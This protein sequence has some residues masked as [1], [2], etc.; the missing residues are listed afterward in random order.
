M[1]KDGKEPFVAQIKF[2][3]RFADQPDKK[4]NG[5]LTSDYPKRDEFSNTIRT[6]Q[7]RE[8]LRVFVSAAESHFSARNEAAQEARGASEDHGSRNE[9]ICASNSTT[10]IP[11]I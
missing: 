10:I 6:E 11:A 8:T 1:S 9:C 3:D 2:K 7:L 5:F 4:K